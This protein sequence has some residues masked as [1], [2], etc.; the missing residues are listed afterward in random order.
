MREG[1][2]PVVF[3]V[4]DQVGSPTQ[5]LVIVLGSDFCRFQALTSPLSDSRLRSRY[6]RG[7]QK[8]ALPLGIPSAEGP[9]V[10]PQR[11]HSTRYDFSATA[12]ASNTR[13]QSTDG[14][15]QDD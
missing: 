15:R 4:F 7:L 2:T 9:P 12:R 5:H 3:E 1:E 10:L 11:S 13:Q 6:L 8:A 14:N